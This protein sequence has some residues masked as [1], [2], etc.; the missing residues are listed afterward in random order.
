MFKGLMRFSNV[1][2]A[3]MSQEIRT[4][5]Q[6]L[7]AKVGLTDARGGACRGRV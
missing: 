4:L 6:T 5:L 3:S 2:P 7:R 1:M